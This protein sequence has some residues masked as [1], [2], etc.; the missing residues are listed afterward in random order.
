M[1]VTESPAVA[2]ECCENKEVTIL[3]L[4]SHMIFVVSLIIKEI[5]K[6]L[7]KKEVVLVMSLCFERLELKTT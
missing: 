3:I 1:S 7:I 6:E 5:K 4:S 2:P